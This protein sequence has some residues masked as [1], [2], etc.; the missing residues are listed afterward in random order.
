MELEVRRTELA[1]VQRPMDARA[2]RS[3]AARAAAEA[4]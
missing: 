1:A 3:T 4:Q 2:A